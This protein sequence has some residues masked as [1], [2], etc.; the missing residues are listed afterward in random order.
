MLRINLEVYSNRKLTVIEVRS[1]LGTTMFYCRMYRNTL[2][3]SLL[4][5][6]PS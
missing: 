5:M 4:H 2:P 6:T 3:F 1:E